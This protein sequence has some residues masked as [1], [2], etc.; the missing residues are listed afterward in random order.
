M[1][2]PISIAIWRFFD[3]FKGEKIQHAH[4]QKSRHMGVCAVRRVS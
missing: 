3:Q 4:T 1:Q 2:E